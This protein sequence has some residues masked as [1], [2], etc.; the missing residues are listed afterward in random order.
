VL[1]SG[2]HPK[3]KVLV[4]LSE[5]VAPWNIKTTGQADKEDE[6]DRLAD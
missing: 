6:T 4:F 1:K 2:V 3:T 5:A